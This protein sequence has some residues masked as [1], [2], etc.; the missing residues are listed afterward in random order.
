[1]KV[2]GCEVVAYSNVEF[3]PG[4]FVRET[5]RQLGLR[6]D[7]EDGTQLD[8]DAT[9]P[10]GGTAPELIA[11]LGNTEKEGGLP[12]GLT[13]ALDVWFRSRGVI[14]KRPRG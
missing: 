7:L 11:V 8:V 12:K 6:I 4:G 5:E 10:P 9:I 14:T 13:K 2:T 1:M 3:L